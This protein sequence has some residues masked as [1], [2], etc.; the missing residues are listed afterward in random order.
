LHDRSNYGCIGGIE[1]QASTKAGFDFIL[2][3]KYQRAFKPEGRTPF[4]QQEYFLI[5]LGFIYKNRLSPKS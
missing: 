5:E 1:I 3:S 4:I 2:T